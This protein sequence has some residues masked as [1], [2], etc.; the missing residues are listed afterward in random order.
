MNCLMTLCATMLVSQAA[1]SMTAEELTGKVLSN[2]SFVQATQNSI[3][4]TFRQPETVKME[5]VA[6]GAYM[7]RAPNFNVRFH[8][9]IEAGRTSFGTCAYTMQGKL[10]ADSSVEFVKL[11]RDECWE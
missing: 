5:F 10:K 2:K 11:T 9:N 4:K 3:K 8:Y 1:F 6:A 7:N